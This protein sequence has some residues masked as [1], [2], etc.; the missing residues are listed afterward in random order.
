MIITVPAR[1][2]AIHILK[3]N[4]MKKDFLI[5]GETAGRLNAYVKI[6]GGLD[7]M[8]GILNG[9]LKFEITNQPFT[10]IQLFWKNLYK[11]Y[12]NLEIDVS[13]IKEVEGKWVIFIAKG[14]TIQQ[15][16]EA[17]PF[18]KWKYADGDLDTAVPTNDRVSDKDYVVYVDQNVEADEQFK[19][20]SA[21]DL[22]KTNH[23]GITLMERLILEL[24]HFEETGKHLDVNKVT[25]CSGSRN[26]D[27][28]VP[29]VD[30]CGGVLEVDWYGAS[31]SD[32]DLRS[33]SVVSA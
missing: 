10:P 18:K 2:R 29:S 4:K 6:L 32:D 30:W 7:V 9:T 11:K 28:G 27:G 16:Y 8:N 23:T 19:N 24:K 22:K 14:L 33:R 3:L 17:L 20:K 1:S 25:L 5:A 31:D 21:N 15:V 13:S 12:F 26:S